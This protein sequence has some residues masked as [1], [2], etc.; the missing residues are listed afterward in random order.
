MVSLPWS[1][2]L[3][4]KLAAANNSPSTKCNNRHAQGKTLRI[5]TAQG[6]DTLLLGCSPSSV[7]WDRCS[8]RS[9]PPGLRNW[10]RLRIP[11]GTNPSGAFAQWGCACHPRGSKANLAFPSLLSIFLLFQ[12]PKEVSK[13]PVFLWP[14]IT[15]SFLIS[16][17][18]RNNGG[19]KWK[20]LG[21]SQSLNKK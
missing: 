18:N 9:V 19:S 11:A 5:L 2:I 12:P 3:L 8:S 15:K 20:T 1:I 10:R 17:N 13:S 16:N 6:P 14:R 4:R 7:T 21:H